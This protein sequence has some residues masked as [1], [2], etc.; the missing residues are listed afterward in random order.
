MRA[1]DRDGELR[2]ADAPGAHWAVALLF[3]GVGA[4]F[5]LGPLGLFV[6]ADSVGW[7]ARG[8]SMVMGGCGVAAGLWMARESP[9]SRLVYARAT[10]R[11]RITRVGTAGRAEGEWEASDIAGVAVA[12]RKDDEGDDVFQVRL[13]LG[14]GDAEPV[15]QL[16]THD[17]EGAARCAATLA[18]A[19][20]VPVA[21]EQDPADRLRG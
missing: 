8:T 16:W 12:T 11:V 2:I 17:A 3:A 10:G 4:V 21:R 6:N 5:V 20:G 9:H 14:R 13:M 1:T 19:L 7:L 18:G 15:S